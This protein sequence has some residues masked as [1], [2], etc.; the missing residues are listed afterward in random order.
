MNTK[1]L[2]TEESPPPTWKKP[3]QFF[4]LNPVWD[5]SM[6]W[7]LEI[8]P[9]NGKFLLWLAEQNPHQLHIAVEIRN[10]RFQNLAQKAREKGLKNLIVIHGDARHCLSFLFH[11]PCLTE[12]FILFPDPWPKRRHHKHRLLNTER[13]EQ[14]HEILKSKGRVWVATDHDEYS[15]QIRSVFPPEKWKYEE[16][17]SLYPTYFETKWKK[18][19]REIHYFCFR[20][21][22]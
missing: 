17:K 10:M 20:K 12:A 3:Y 13:T 6:E 22:V 5:E 11:H 21:S 16:G 9:G 14:L 8:G 2:T 15:G 4:P 19:G 1:P 7:V 18:L